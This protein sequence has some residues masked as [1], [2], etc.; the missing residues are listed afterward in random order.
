MAVLDTMAPE[1]REL[2]G[3]IGEADLVVALPSCQS[4]ELLDA[5]VAGLRPVLP[6]LL[7]NGKTVI[8]HPDTAIA[9]MDG[10]TEQASDDASLHLF[11]Y[12]MSLEERYHEQSLDQ[13]L[14]S[15]LQVGKALGARTCVMMGLQPSPD[16]LQSLAEP[17][18]NNGY[19]LCVPLYA[20]RKFD[21]LINSGIVYPLTRA[22]Y[23]ARL[24]YPMAA[25]LA[26]SSRLAEKYLQPSAPPGQ[27][28][29]GWITTK[30]VCAGLQVCQVHRDFAP[31]PGVSEPSDLSASLARIL[32]TL[33]VDVERNAAFW[34]KVHGSQP[35]RTFGKPAPVES[36]SATVNVHKMVETFQR[37]CTDLLDIWVKVLSPAT[38]LELKKLVKLPVDQFHLPDAIWVHVLYDFILGHRQRV[39]SR[40]HLLR[41]MT[42]IYL[43][44]VAAYALE[45]QNMAPDAV[46]NRLEELFASFETLKPYLLSRWRWPDRFNP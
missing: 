38:L 6:A 9:L 42:P 19:D 11:P 30:A 31:A 27:P 18:L 20:H 17:V 39:I 8:L 22:L 43:G 45:V 1:A 7:P 33:F 37:G 12:P 3:R 21:S 46:E 28:E 32:G 40:E 36:E 15:L 24:R 26:L 23:G 41:A 29:S 14:R 35:V 2:A 16:A 34:Q 10:K 4:R 13:G 44:W 5:A 25:D